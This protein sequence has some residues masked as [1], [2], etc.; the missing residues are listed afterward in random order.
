LT[1]LAGE[2]NAEILAVWQPES[3][4]S[5]LTVALNGS[6]HAHLLEGPNPSR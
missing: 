3:A 5:V 2:T 1:L 6:V 4:Q